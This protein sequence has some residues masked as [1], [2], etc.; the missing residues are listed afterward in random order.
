M[1]G[2]AIIT[3]VQVD[4]HTRFFLL[5][6]QVPGGAALRSTQNVWAP[7]HISCNRRGG[8][9]APIQR[10]LQPQAA[11]ARD[12]PAC[13]HNVSA[14]GCFSC[15]VLSFAGRRLDVLPHLPSSP[16]VLVITLF[17]SPWRRLLALMA[18][19]RK[20][21]DGQEYTL[22]E[23]AENRTF[24]VQQCCAPADGIAAN[25]SS[26][27]PPHCPVEPAVMELPRLF[28]VGI[29]E[30]YRESEC[31]LAWQLN[32]PP[33]DQARMCTPETTSHNS[34]SRDW[35]LA[36]SV[37]DALNQ[38][39]QD[40]VLYSEA[41]HEFRGRQA[42]A[43]ARGW[44]PPSASDAFPEP[45]PMLPSP[46]RLA[47]GRPQKPDVTSASKVLLVV[48]GLALLTTVTMKLLLSRWVTAQ[49]SRHPKRHEETAEGEVALGL[50]DHSARSSGAGLRG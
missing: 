12:N 28:F 10:Y 14:P 1:A 48:V 20:L 33:D 23:V 21:H 8:S 37:S 35:M 7:G 9:L 5:Q 42:R 26:H 41:L 13:T 30:L 44:R 31:L 6:V 46:D 40:Q 11:R 39:W 29:L 45:P 47:T 24:V 25:Y 27:M 3:P 17:R 50:L 34:A 4:D 43:E 2:D 15:S 36:G 49:R 16:G 18:H 22:Q 32:L 19:D 38:C